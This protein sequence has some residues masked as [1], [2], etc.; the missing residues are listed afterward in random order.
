ME[1]KIT[2]TKML[3]ALMK[4]WAVCKNVNREIEILRMDQKEYYK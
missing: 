4:K 3:R 2:M 1:C